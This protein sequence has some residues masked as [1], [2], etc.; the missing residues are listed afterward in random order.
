M[1]GI[2]NIMKIS[3][4]LDILKKEEVLSRTPFGRPLGDYAVKSIQAVIGDTKNHDN[5]L[6]KCLGCGLVISILLTSEGC[7]NCG[8]EELTTE[9]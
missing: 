8:V 4:G 7:P 2:S 3:E 1:L 9:I 6:V 5:E